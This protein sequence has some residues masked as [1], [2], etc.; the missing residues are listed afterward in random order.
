MEI[1]LRRFEET[2]IVDVFGDM[3]MYNASGVKDIF[4]KMVEKQIGRIVI[5]LEHVEYIDSSGV[6][7]L[8]SIYASVRQK[9]I[10]FYL[11]NVHGTVNK[12]LTLTK[13][14]GFF[15]SAQSVDEAVMKIKN[16]VEGV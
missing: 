8:I 10:L 15:P 12:V 14:D 7:V 5:N 13:L 9:N 11:S 6:G 1:K 3:D 4:N 2:Y 16:V